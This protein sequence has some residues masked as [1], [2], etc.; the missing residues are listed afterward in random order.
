MNRRIDDIIKGKQDGPDWKYLGLIGLIIVSTIVGMIFVPQFIGFVAN[1]SF[2]GW[3]N[4]TTNDLKSDTVR[5][6]V[7]NNATGKIYY[8]KTYTYQITSKIKK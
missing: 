8:D 6:V 1:N 5:I 3:F 2:A 7:A 4:I